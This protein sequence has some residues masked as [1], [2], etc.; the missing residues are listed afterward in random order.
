MTDVIRLSEFHQAALLVFG[1]EGGH[2]FAGRQR[3][4]LQVGHALERPQDL[5][6]LRGMEPG[7]R[8]AAGSRFG[9]NQDAVFRIAQRGC[10]QFGGVP[11]P[12]D[13]G[14]LH[15]WQAKRHPRRN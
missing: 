12:G 2:G 4:N 7:Q 11:R 14:C 1:D 6:L 8:L 3:N 5:A 10:P 9:L 13:I 15:T